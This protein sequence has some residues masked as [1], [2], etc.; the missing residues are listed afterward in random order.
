MLTAIIAM[1]AFSLSVPQ[2]AGG[3]VAQLKGPAQETSPDQVERVEAQAAR[4]LVQAG[5]A[6]LVC[7]YNSDE[8]FAKVK[9][10]GA[11]PLS[12]FNKRLATLDKESLVIFYCA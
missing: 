11:I 2:V 9:L 7:A 8:K 6:L 10:E 12:E 4:D 1:A 3:A 5:K